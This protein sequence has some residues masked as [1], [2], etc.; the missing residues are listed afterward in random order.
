MQPYREAI[1][2]VSYIHVVYSYND[3]NYIY[4]Y[5]RTRHLDI[6]WN[7]L[8]FEEG[9]GGGSSQ[10][11]WLT[12]CIKRQKKGSN[13]EVADKHDGMFAIILVVIDGQSIL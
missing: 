10:L 8:F 3:I 2:I 13:F 7:R 4:L 12:C 9:G 5:M 6:Q 11:N 1:D